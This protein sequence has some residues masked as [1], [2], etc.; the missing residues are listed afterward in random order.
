MTKQEQA[1]RKLLDRVRLLKASAKVLYEEAIDIENELAG[2]Y[3]SA[4]VKKSGKYE[5]SDEERAR[6]RA[7]SCSRRRIPIDYK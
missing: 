2:F 7:E 6:L 3:P 4:P 1:R 5:L